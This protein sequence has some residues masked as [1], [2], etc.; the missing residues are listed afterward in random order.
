MSKQREMQLFLNQSKKDM[1]FF[2]SKIYLTCY[3]RKS[4][5][6]SERVIKIV[7]GK[8]ATMMT[9]FDSVF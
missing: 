3:I 5:E 8:L 1:A 6:K 9:A 4:S 2:Y 7:P